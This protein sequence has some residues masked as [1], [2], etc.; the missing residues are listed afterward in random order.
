ML[1]SCQND[2]T[3]ISDYSTFFGYNCLCPPGVDG[4]EC[5]D[6]Y[7]LCQSDTCWNN[8]KFN[9]TENVESIQSYF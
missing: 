1:D 6:D 9:K 8:G 7:R 2:G 4:T 3:C 5:Q